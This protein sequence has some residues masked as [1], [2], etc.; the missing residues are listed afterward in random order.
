[1]MRYLRPNN[2]FTFV[3]LLVVISLISLILCIAV[4]RFQDTLLSDNTNQVSRWIMAKVQALKAKAVR[5][6]K[7]YVLNVS[8]DFNRMWT[9]HT[10]MS[11]EELQNAS[12]NAFKLPGDLKLRDV[13]YPGNEII[14]GGQADINF[15]KKGYSD[16]ALIHIEDGNDEQLSFVVEPFLPRVRVHQKYVGFED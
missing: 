12:Q 8:L 9:T 10:L 16:M 4:P 11:E 7:R 1:M 13:E 15:Y 2:G 6:Q 5:D 14:S 3:E